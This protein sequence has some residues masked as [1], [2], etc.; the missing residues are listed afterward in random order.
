MEP[1]AGRRSCEWRIAL[2]YSAYRYRSAYAFPSYSYTYPSYGY[3]VYSYP[4]YGYSPYA[5]G[6]NPYAYRS[7]GYRIRWPF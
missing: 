1:A 6:Y 3:S 4:S 7:Y 2:R 5:Y